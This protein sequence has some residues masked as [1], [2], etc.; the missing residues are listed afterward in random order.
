MET[1]MLN[2]L[3][4]YLKRIH[5]DERGAMSVEKILIILAVAVPILV[6]IYLFVQN[7][8][9]PGFAASQ[10]SLGFN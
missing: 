3:K 1:H 5:S 4:K 8:L 9:L 6:A 10:K 2:G 7:K